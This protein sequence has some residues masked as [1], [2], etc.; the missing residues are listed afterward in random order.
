MIA[1]LRRNNNQSSTPLL[2][3]FKQTYERMPLTSTSPSVME[4]EEARH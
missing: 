1:N 3:I 2:R 4:G